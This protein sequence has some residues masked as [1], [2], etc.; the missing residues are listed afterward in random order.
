MAINL[1]LS[2]KACFDILPD[3]AHD[4]GLTLSLPWLTLSL[5]AGLSA[6]VLLLNSL[7]KKSSRLQGLLR[8]LRFLEW[9]TDDTKTAKFRQK[10]IDATIYAFFATAIPCFSM[11]LSTLS[12]SSI[13][14]AQPHDDSEPTAVSGQ[15]LLARPAVEC[16]RSPH[17]S[18]AIAASV[19]LVF[20]VLVLPCSFVYLLFRVGA[21]GV[22]VNDAKFKRKFG[23]LYMRYETNKFFWH[24]VFYCAQTLLILI[25]NFAMNVDPELQVPCT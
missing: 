22:R 17:Q 12:C 3:F 20:Y 2:F 18:V 5:N 15:Y 24:L 11:A 9:V 8:A 21:G 7:S 19:F 10:K 4:V 14:D 6:G 13:V 16:W 1:N 23:F 25:R